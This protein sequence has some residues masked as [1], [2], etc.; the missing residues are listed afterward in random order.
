MEIDS[1]RAS[2]EIGW[3]SNR[4]TETVSVRK[5]YFTNIVI[6]SAF[7][8]TLFDTIINKQVLAVLQNTSATTYMIIRMDRNRE[9]PRKHEK[10]MKT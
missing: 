5:N 2:L 7:K 1:L 4:W 6:M 8:C 9:R 10:M 3:Y